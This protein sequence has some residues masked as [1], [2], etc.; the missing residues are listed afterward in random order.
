MFQWVVVLND[1][2]GE[3]ELGAQSEYDVSEEVGELVDVVKGGVLSACQLQHQPHVQGDAVDLH[4]EGNHSAGYV[5]LSVEGVHETPD[6]LWTK[7]EKV[8]C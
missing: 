6:H 7:Q 8:L 1:V 2:P 4:K 5:Q 3:V